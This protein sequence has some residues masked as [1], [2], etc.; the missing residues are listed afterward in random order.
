M[1]QFE[2]GIWKIVGTN[3]RFR[4]KVDFKL[5]AHYSIWPIPGRDFWITYCYLKNSFRLIIAKTIYFPTEFVIFEIH[6][7]LVELVEKLQG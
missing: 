6:E 1:L 7:N 2:F 5:K 3:F 4:E